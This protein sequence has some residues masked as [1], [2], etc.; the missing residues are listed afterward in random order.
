MGRAPDFHALGGTFPFIVTLWGR[1]K[2]LGLL[3]IRQTIQQSRHHSVFGVE[4]S[5]LFPNFISCR[6]SADYRALRCLSFLICKS[7]LEEHLPR[8]RG[9]WKGP[10]AGALQPS[11]RLPSS[12][13]AGQMSYLL[14]QED[15]GLFRGLSMR[16]FRV[17]RGTSQ[18]NTLLIRRG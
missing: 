15:S 4:L 5:R 14:P 8:E 12:A 13:P 16:H 9:D 18:R 7:G 2:I 17:L 1:N 11:C 6:T 10:S 3:L